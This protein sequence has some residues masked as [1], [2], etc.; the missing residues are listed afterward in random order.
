[1]ARTL[2]VRLAFD[3]PEG[4]L[5]ANMFADAVIYGGPK[6]G[7]LAVPAEAIIETGQRT[8][9]VLALGDGRFQPIDVVTG[10]ATGDFVEIL[11]GVKAG[12]EV[13]VSGQFLIDSE[14][15]LQASFMRMDES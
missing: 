15:S 8:S 7:A 5:K 1:M 13:V 2:K 11:S 3:N 12:D 6:R 10:M 14:S 4:L 9:V